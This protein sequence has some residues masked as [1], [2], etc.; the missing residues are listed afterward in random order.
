[1]GRPINEENMK[2]AINLD[3]R[4]VNVSIMTKMSL[5]I[6]HQMIHKGRYKIQFVFN[7]W[8]YI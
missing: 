5:K 2:E 7:I 3:L 4:Q 8:D 6:G 1:M